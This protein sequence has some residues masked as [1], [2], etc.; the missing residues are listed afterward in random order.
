[1]APPHEYGHHSHEAGDSPKAGAQRRSFAP[2]PKQSPV[3]T[4]PSLHGKKLL[5]HESR[6]RLSGIKYRN[7]KIHGLILQLTAWY[8]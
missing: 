4:T 1:M 3:G 6:I 7:V 8:F 2:Y 5:A